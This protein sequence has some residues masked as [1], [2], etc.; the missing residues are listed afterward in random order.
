ML[1]ITG[2]SVAQTSSPEYACLH[3]QQVR[4]Q[5]R[6]RSYV[7]ESEKSAVHR[8]LHRISE[9]FRRRAR[10]FP[11]IVSERRRTEG[12]GVGRTCARREPA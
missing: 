12:D 3:L 6:L 5:R 10:L 11:V 9:Y 4:E 8:T 2:S 7:L 1:R